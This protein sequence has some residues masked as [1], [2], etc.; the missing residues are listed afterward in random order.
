MGPQPFD[1]ALMNFHVIG[2]MTSND[3]VLKGFDATG[4]KTIH[5]R[6]GTIPASLRPPLRIKRRRRRT[7]SANWA[8][9][10]MFTVTWP[11]GP[12]TCNHVAVFGSI[13]G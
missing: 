6:Q 13:F 8:Y 2:Y 7:L 9:K 4:P 3:D 11:I 1:V 10:A 5:C 12:L